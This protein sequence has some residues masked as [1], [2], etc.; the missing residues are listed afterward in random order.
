VAPNGEPWPAQSG[1]VGGYGVR[2]SGGLSELTIDNRRNDADM[3]VRLFALDG[4]QAYAVRTVLVRAHGSFTLTGLL[5]GSYDLRYRSLGDGRLSR[6]QFFTLE[7]VAT[8][9]GVRSDRLTVPLRHP[10]DAPLQ[11]FDLVEA[12]FQ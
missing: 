8:A 7:E 4:P 10:G 6:S 3:F 12:E 1:Y 5:S 9:R 11:T 2:N